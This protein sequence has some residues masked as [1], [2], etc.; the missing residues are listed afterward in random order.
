MDIYGSN[1]YVCGGEWEDASH[2]KAKYWMNGIS[3]DLTDGSVLAYATDID[4][5]Q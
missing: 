1:I 4:V 2:L 3:T 5:V